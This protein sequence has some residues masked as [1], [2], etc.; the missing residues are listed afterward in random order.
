MLCE[1]NYLFTATGEHLISPVA[2]RFRA[3]DEIAA[4]LDAAGFAIDEVYGD[5][6]RRLA[7]P[8]EK[9]IIVVA[10]S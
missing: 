7:G 10:R 2:L 1:D 6:D 8:G 4:S 9:E 5:W 3:L